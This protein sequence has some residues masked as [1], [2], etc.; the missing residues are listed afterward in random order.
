MQLL[1]LT[2]TQHFEMTAPRSARP[3]NV[4]VAGSGIAGPP[5]A[6]FLAAAGHAVT[7]VERSPDLR[8][9]GQSIDVRGHGLRVLQRMEVEDKV[10][11]R[12]THE[13]GLKFVDA[14]DS[15]RAAFPVDD[16]KGFTSDLEV[17]RGDLARC[18]YDRSKETGVNYVFGEKITSAEDGEDG[19]VVQFAHGKQTA[20]YDVVV[21][22][23]GWA[24]ATRRTV[25][26]ELVHCE[27]IKP[28]LQWSAWFTIP[29]KESDGDWARWYNA[30]QRRMILIRPDKHNNV[31]RVSFWIMDV[32]DKMQQALHK[33]I[34]AQKALWRSLFKDAGWEAPRCLA[35]LDAADDFYMQQ[36]AQVKMSGAWSKGRTVLLG[37]A[38][39]CPSPISGMGTTVALVGAYVLAGEL[40]KHAN[41]PTTAFAAYER[42]MRPFVQTAQKLAPGAPR[43]ANPASSWGI[44]F[45]YGFLGFVAWS[46]LDKMMGASVNPPS[47]AM[48][49]PDYTMRDS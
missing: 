33:D 19:V 13:A 8:T 44:T 16:G 32:E 3:L 14:T 9:S 34:A 5:C 36:I 42:R 2:P 40:I 39:C 26:G 43:M 49:L 24:S 29:S 46:G 37:D 38:A 41:N 18:L 23:D 7:V 30:P 1:R 15:T 6:H 21:A 22:A 27:A 47:E 10:R 25:F 31:T 35:A 17:M 28:L 4:L 11:A 12:A 45:M 48:D 20:R